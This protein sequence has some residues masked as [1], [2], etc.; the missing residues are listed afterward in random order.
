MGIVDCRAGLPVRNLKGSSFVGATRRRGTSRSACRVSKFEGGNH[1][2]IDPQQ[3][4]SQH[5]TVARN[6]GSEDYEQIAH[7]AF[8]R[9]S[10]EQRTQ[11]GE[12]LVQQ[13]RQQ[14]FNAPAFSQ[15]GGGFDP[16]R[17]AQMAGELHRQD[18]G[19]LGN[20]L[21]GGSGAN[22]LQSNAAKLALAGIT[23]MAIKRLQKR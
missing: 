8:S 2:Q 6:V 19:L 17:L 20:L 21:G 16:S 12:T 23:A 7:E 13:A 10:P 15:Q 9:L 4:L 14:D 18:P 1:E 3:A 11:L 22:P 5:E